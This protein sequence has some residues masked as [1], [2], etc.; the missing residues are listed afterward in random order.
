MNDNN[1]YHNTVIFIS[2]FNFCFKN[3]N[4]DANYE[5]YDNTVR[6]RPTTEIE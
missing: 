3:K 1:T 2:L 5:Q 4:K 6:N